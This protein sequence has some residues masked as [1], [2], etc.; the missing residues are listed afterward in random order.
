MYRF[1]DESQNDTETKGRRDSHRFVPHV[2][3]PPSNLLQLGSKRESR[4]TSLVRSRRLTLVIALFRYFARR[5]RDI[6]REGRIGG[7]VWGSVKSERK[8]V[9]TAW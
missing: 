8:N 3:L 6:H 5:L 1:L 7:A 4:R 9:V 2:H